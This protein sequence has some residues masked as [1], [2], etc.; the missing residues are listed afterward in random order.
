MI[1]SRCH[2]L[3]ACILCSTIIFTIIP[4]IINKSVNADTI[5]NYEGDKPSSDCSYRSVE[6]AYFT[7]EV[8]TPNKWS[9]H[10]NI[11]IKFKNTE[12]KLSTTGISHLIL[13]TRSK[14]LLTAEL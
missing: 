2:R 7:A 14:T 1:D 5:V 8:K 12:R 10:S 11:E 3:L 6:E 13:I 9:G 4:N